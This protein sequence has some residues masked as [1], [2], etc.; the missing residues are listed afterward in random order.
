MI[1]IDEIISKDVPG[2][3]ALKITFPYNREIINIIKQLDY[4]VYKEDDHS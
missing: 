2:T 4:R 3:T 1:V